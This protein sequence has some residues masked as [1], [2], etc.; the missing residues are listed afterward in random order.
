MLANVKLWQTTLKQALTLPGVQ[1]NR[2]KFLRHIL[3]QVGVD[4]LT[5]AR[6]CAGA[7]LVSLPLDRIDIA[8]KRCI[9]RHSAQVSAISAISGIPGGI[10]GAVSVPAD[11]L[12]YL[13]HVLVLAQKLSYLYGYPSLTDE[14]GKL[15]AKGQLVLTLLC[16][17]MFGDDNAKAALHMVMRKLKGEKVPLKEMKSPLL[18]IAK[19]SAAFLG[20]G[21]SK[22]LAARGLTRLVP[23]I[24]ALTA[25]AM[26]LQSFYPKACTLQQSLREHYIG[27]LNT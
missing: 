5:V 9:R 14:H 4:E 24:S 26:T 7:T 11:L 15:T 16:G 20:K 27:K 21:L 17:L 2:E 6:L 13:W 22:A 19:G 10:T 3:P 23:V 8:A 12:Q 1:V 25:G 18:T